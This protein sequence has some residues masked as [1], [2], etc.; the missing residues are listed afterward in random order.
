MNEALK[1]RI[2]IHAHPVPAFLT[3]A[4]SA[5]GFRASIS[6]GFPKWSAVLALDFM[7]ANGIATTINSISQPGVN[8][9]DDA[10]ARALARQC[11]E[12]FAQLSAQ[13]PRRFGSFAALPLPDVDGAIAEA[14]Y[15][16]EV[17]KLDAVGVLA[18]YG[19]DFFG[20]KKFDP[21]LAFLNDKS[22]IV[23]IHPNYHPSSKTIGMDV[24]GF[25]VEFTFDTTRAAV[26]LIFGGAMERFPRVRFVLAHNGGT[27]P[28]LGWR[29]AMAPL[30]D[31]HFQSFSRESILV[32]LR[33]FYYDCAQ[34]AGR[35]T[36]AAMREIADPS[37]L[38]FGSDWPYCP[39]SVTEAGDQE[40]LVQEKS[41]GVPTADIFRNNALT[42]FPKFG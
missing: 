12:L 33:G 17:L 36:M 13:Y 42:L 9:G 22:A 5:A 24:P 38:L 37:H 2:D 3:E 32:A 18:S 21:L 19:T 27:I 16:L 34:A 1:N 28:F 14:R 29:L 11:N 15:A 30:I 8:Y 23:F 40:L 35:G 25:L 39:E 31:K 10:A 20:D 7:D 6:A 41:G 4:A 26:N